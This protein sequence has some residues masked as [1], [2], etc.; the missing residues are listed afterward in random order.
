MSSTL[1]SH[2]STGKVKEKKQGQEATL[3][4][5]DAPQVFHWERYLL[6]PFLNLKA[7]PGQGVC[8]GSLVTRL[9]ESGISRKT[10][11][12]DSLPINKLAGKDRWSSPLVSLALLSLPV[13][14]TTS[15]GS[16]SRQS[17]G[18]ITH[19][20]TFAPL[21]WSFGVHHWVLFEFH[22]DME[23][24]KTPSFVELICDSNSCV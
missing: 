14:V 2:I 20:H 17:P 4:Y 15:P 18:T 1:A 21:R 12:C 16:Q 8:L 9:L 7:F 6:F 11:L 5:W 13:P 10:A 3:E 19:R 23:N 22:I 24:K